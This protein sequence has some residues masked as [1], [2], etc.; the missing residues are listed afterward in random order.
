MMPS[1]RRGGRC[2]PTHCRGKRK[3]RCSGEKSRLHV[4]LLEF[5]GPCSRF[6]S[7]APAAIGSIPM[8]RQWFLE[9]RRR[10]KPRRSAFFALASRVSTGAAPRCRGPLPGDAF[11][12]TGRVVRLGRT[13]DRNRR[14]GHIP[15]DLERGGRTDRA[16]WHRLRTAAC[17]SA[18]GCGRED[19]MPAVSLTVNGKA[20]KA[21]VDP[22]TLLVQLLREELRLTGTHVGC[23]TSQCGCCVHVDGKA[24]KS[25]TMLALQAE[26]SSVLTIEGPIS[27]DF[28]AA[29]SHLQIADQPVGN[30]TEN[31]LVSRCG[32]SMRMPATSSGSYLRSTPAMTSALFSWSASRSAA[33]RWRYPTGYR[34]SRPG[35]RPPCS[36]G[37]RHR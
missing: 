9:L 33:D 7:P 8:M 3:R 5:S 4:V 32:R 18:S 2:C 12:W 11:S 35:Y 10:E 30:C 15:R 31:V 26:G 6:R 34:S 17:P 13:L 22:R 27:A 14:G 16:G 1:L 36:A 20:I 24:I 29:A 21:N 19:A 28:C 23:D 37:N 25:C